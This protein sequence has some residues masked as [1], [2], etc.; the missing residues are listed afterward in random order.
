LGP[1]SFQRDVEMI[2]RCT[3]VVTGLSKK[4]NKSNKL[5]ARLKKLHKQTPKTK[6]K[7]VTTSVQNKET[8]IWN[9]PSSSAHKRHTR[10]SESKKVSGFYFPAV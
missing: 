4:L 3:G 2:K 7:V 1:V 10:L 6:L 5:L 8:K 9:E